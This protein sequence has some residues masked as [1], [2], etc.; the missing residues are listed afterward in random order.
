M[1]EKTSKQDGKAWK[2][3]AGGGTLADPIASAY[4]NQRESRKLGQPIKP[5]SLSSESY[6]FQQ[7][8]T[9]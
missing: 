6:F 3:G 9:F 5:Q 1:A 8:S 2:G 4:R 7:D